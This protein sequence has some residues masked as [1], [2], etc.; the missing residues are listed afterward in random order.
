MAHESDSTRLRLG[1]T[2]DPGQISREAT[3]ARLGRNVSKEI[4]PHF[5]ERSVASRIEEIKERARERVIGIT[6]KAAADIA[7]AQK[8]GAKK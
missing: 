3:E 5:E 6:Q 7:K 8:S 4:T 2:T 1:F